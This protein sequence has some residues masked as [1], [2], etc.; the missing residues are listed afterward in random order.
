MD[1]LLSVGDDLADGMFLEY[2]CEGSKK[3]GFL[4]TFLSLS[5]APWYSWSTA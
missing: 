1:S 2:V 5:L 4:S 3:S